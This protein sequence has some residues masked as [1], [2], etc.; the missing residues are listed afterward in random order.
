MLIKEIRYK[1]SKFMTHKQI[2]DLIQRQK[3]LIKIDKPRIRDPYILKRMLIDQLK[4]E[5]YILNKT[6]NY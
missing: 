2:S 5:L 1:L 4:K 3:N 6:F